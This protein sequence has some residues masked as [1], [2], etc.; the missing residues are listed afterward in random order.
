MQFVKGGPDIPEQLLQAHEDGQVVFFCGAGISR[1]AGLPTFA[2]LVAQLYATMNMDADLAEDAA[3][4]ADQHDTAVGLLEARVMG[5]RQKVRKELARILIPKLD[6][7]N[8]TTTHEA[9]LTLGKDRKDRTRLITTNFDRLFEEVITRTQPQVERFR[10]PLLPVPKQR[11]DGLVYLHGLLTESPSESDLERLVVSSGDF[12]LAYLTER[13]AARFV[14]EL[15][16]N[17]VVCFVGYSINDP[18]LRY[19]MDALA[20]DRLLGESPLEIF[21]FGSYSKGKAEKSEREWRAKNVTPILYREH[22]HHAY[23]HRTLWAWSKTYRD[24]AQGKEQIVIESAMALP[25]AST[26]QDDFVGRLI[27]ALSDPSGRPARRFAELDPVPSLEWLKPLSENRFRHADLARFGI[28][29]NSTFD[30]GLEFSLTR[31]PSPYKL[32]PWMALV[33]SGAES[34]LW[35]NVMTQIAQWLVRHLGDPAVL[36]WLTEPGNVL[37]KD[38]AQCI[39]KNLEWLD[40]TE[41]NGDQAALE[42]IRANAPNA[43]PGQKIRTLWRLLLK[44]RV[45]TWVGDYDFHRWYEQFQRDGLTVILR[46]DLREKLVPRVMLEKLLALPFGD[47]KD[48]ADGQERMNKSVYA[49]VVLSAKDVRPC[50]QKLADDERWVEALPELLNEFTGLLRDALDLMRELG[51]ANERSDQ[52]YSSQPS[53]SE[54]SQNH[55]S[56]DWT[57]LIELARDAWLAT[58][59]RSPE[60]ARAAAEAWWQIPYPVFRRLAFFSATQ[61]EII[62]RRQALDWLLSDACWW[63]WSPQTLREAMRLLVSLAPRLEEAELDLVEQ[64]ILAGPPRVMYPDD[65]Q[66]EDWTRLQNQEIWLRLAKLAEGGAKLGATGAKRRDEI[67]ARYPDWQLAEDELYEFPI[68]TR[69]WSEGREF[70]ETPRELPE[71][72]EWLKANADNDPWQRDNWPGRCRKDFDK[73]SSALSELA[74]QGIWPPRPWREA[75]FV[76]SGEKL[77]KRSWDDMAQILNQMPDE[78]LQALSYEASL[79]LRT[80]AEGFEGQEAIFLKLCDRLLKLKHEDEEEDNNSVRLAISH[81]VGRVTDALL[82]WWYRRPLK[83]DQGLDEDL[84]LRFSMICETRV[85]KLRHGRV[86]LAAHVI[87]LFRVDRDWATQYVLPLFNWTNAKAEAGAAWQGFLWSP[88]LYRPLME[89]LKSAFLEAASHYE[90]LGEHGDEYPSLLTFVAMEPEDIFKRRELARATAALP[91]EGLDNAAETLMRALEGAGGQ[92]VEY[93]RNRIQP[94]L[95]NVWP[96]TQNIASASIA[97]SFARVCLAAADAFPEALEEVDLWLQGAAHPT[98]HVRRLRA[99]KLHERFPEATLEFLDKIIG[100]TTHSPPRELEE[101]LRAIC[102]KTPKLAANH[103]F[104]RLVEC[105]Q[106]HGRALD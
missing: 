7:R 60:A 79:W 27:W 100:E 39:E 76:W 33:D 103:R 55:E 92:S 96:K 21:A 1:P 31:R 37:H 41:Q 64:A 19:M 71:L 78:T 9:L 10:A 5:G 82:R 67:S 63:L 45:R 14:S 44:G 59:A 101:L 22:W 34:Q 25:L 61:D 85:G 94:Y 88:R 30:E 16:R 47:E 65:I 53:I 73:T 77:I 91:Q 105:L 106:V 69:K 23:L 46:F 68:W 13:W 17:F 4:K 50:L 56:R 38:M 11:W 66:Q 43:I 83:D 18:V 86:L 6:A 84:K 8:A 87:A 36:L 52:S 97:D 35:D 24:G 48:E 28:S 75:L 40:R 98:E 26:E 80:L 58:C 32:A 102:A 54:H 12:G 74:T 49:E 99:M 20:A 81:P 93:W 62:P 15:L 3:I 42:K 72:I 90:E 70:V 89:A 51:E 2:G 104:Q 95:K 57:A 29:P